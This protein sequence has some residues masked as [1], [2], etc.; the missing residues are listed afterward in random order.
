MQTAFL[1]VTLCDQVDRKIRDFI[2]GSA[3]GVRKVI[4]SKYLRN[5]DSGYIPARSSGFSAAWRGILKAGPILNN[6]TQWAIRNGRL[7]KFWTDKWLDSGLILIDHAFHVQGVDLDSSVADFVLECGSWNSTLILSCLPLHVA[8][9]VLG[10]TPPD[11][12][13]GTDSV[14]WGLEPSGKFTIRSAYLLL[15][16]L[17]DETTDM[18]WKGVWR[19]SGPNKIRHFLWLVSHNRLLTNEERCRRHLTTQVLCSFCS[20][21][22]ESCIHILR[23]CTFARQFWSRVLPQVITDNELSKD[24]GVW[25]DEH[26]RNHRY[27]LIFGVGVWLLWRARNKRVFEQDK[28]TFVDVAHRCDYWVALI[29]SS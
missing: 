17:Q 24:W 22:T 11:S 20:S 12:Q 23:D 10:M 2:W 25:L 26:I 21:H 4:L 9:Q 15:K 6:G 27:S 5:T 19:W 16:E 7:T 18:R 28:E 1:P 14:V 13:L 3:D 8:N 29:N